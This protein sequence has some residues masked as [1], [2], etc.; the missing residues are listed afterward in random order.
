MNENNLYQKYI[1]RKTGEYQQEQ[2][3]SGGF[4]GW[5]YNS[6]RGI[7]FR[8]WLMESDFLHKCVEKFANS[9]LSRH[10]VPLFAKK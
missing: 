4:F 6:P 7:K 2:I 1:I 8:P 5:L 10:L 9:N 3:L